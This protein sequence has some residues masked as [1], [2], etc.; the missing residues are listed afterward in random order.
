M[1]QIFHFRLE[2]TTIGL[3]DIK[4]SAGSGAFLTAIEGVGHRFQVGQLLEQFQ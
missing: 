3:L 2:K 4:L 1:F